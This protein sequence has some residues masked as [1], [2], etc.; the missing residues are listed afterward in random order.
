[1]QRIESVLQWDLSVI[2]SPS[3]FSVGLRKNERESKYLEKFCGVWSQSYGTYVRTKLAYGLAYEGR[4]DFGGSECA[5]RSVFRISKNT[6]LCFYLTASLLFH[7]ASCDMHFHTCYTK[8]LQYRTS[9][10]LILDIKLASRNN[11]RNFMYIKYTEDSGWCPPWL[12]MT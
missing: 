12:G 6:D 10:A 3:Q 11:C 8:Q 1:M 7:N 9:A 2:L 4:T 5:C